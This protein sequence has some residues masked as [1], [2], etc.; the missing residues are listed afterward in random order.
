MTATAELAE[1]LDVRLTPISPKTAT[2]TSTA[3]SASAAAPST[4][5]PVGWLTSRAWVAHCLYP[6]APEITRLGAAGVGVAHCPSSNMVLGNDRICPVTDLRAAGTPVGLGC[7]G[8]S[9]NDIA[10]LWLEARTRC[11][12][13]RCAAA[14][15]R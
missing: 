9:S 2:R 14:R 11:C 13:A 5:S 3:S 15:G 10:S 1:R 12:S 6:D 8:S 7:D 4:S